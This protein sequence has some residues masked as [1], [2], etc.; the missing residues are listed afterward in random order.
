MEILDLK[1]HLNVNNIHRVNITPENNWQQS[2][3]AGVQHVMGSPTLPEV[4]GPRDSLY[5]DHHYFVNYPKKLL[6]L[7]FKCFKERL[8]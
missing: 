6:L 5:I 4:T 3:I 8:C 1:T 2:P 7:N